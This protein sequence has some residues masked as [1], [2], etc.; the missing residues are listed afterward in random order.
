MVKIIIPGNIYRTTC[1]CCQA[2]LSYEKEDMQ[3]TMIK[4]NDHLSHKMNTFIKC[5]QCE[6]KIILEGLIL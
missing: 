6:N 1:N 3:Q 5:P 4:V 2:V